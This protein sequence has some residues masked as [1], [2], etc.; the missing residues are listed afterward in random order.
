MPLQR[1]RSR[2][3]QKFVLGQQSQQHLLESAHE[4]TMHWYTVQAGKMS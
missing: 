4:L 1:Q 3:S 2:L